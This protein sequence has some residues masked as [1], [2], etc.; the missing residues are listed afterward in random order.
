[1]MQKRVYFY[2]PQK[3]KTIAVHVEDL[4]WFLSNGLDGY[5]RCSYK[6]YRIIA[7]FK[8]PAPPVGVDMTVL[9]EIR[10]YEQLLAGSLS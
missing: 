2:H 5:Q 9:D 3:R 10:E 4:R 1:M 8:P 6:T 7:A